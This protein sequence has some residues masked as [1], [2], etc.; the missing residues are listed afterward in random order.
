MED[1]KS[2]SRGIKRR[3]SQ[4]STPTSPS[5]LR[6]STTMA[7]KE[8]T[9]SP[10]NSKKKRI[11]ETIESVNAKSSAGQVARQ[12]ERSIESGPSQDDASTGNITGPNDTEEDDDDD[13][14][15]REMA[16]G[17]ETD[18]WDSSDDA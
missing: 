12:D 5:K 2:T 1:V 6:L 17:G 16:E 11:E 3:R 9:P 10:P 4:T 18:E 13:F 14:L 8:E 7:H 15:A